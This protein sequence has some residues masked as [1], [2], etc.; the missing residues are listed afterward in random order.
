MRKSILIVGLIMAVGL[1]G[2][3]RSRQTPDLPRQSRDV[4]APAPTRRKSALPKKSKADSRALLA[5]KGKALLPIVVSKDASKR[6][7]LAARELAGFLKRISGAEFEVVQGDGQRGIVVGTL[8][9]FPQP[10]A[11]GIAKALEIRNGFDGKEAYVIRSK[12]ERVLLL[13]ATELG[14]SHAVYRLLERLGC[15]WFFPAKEW[16]V[17]PSAPTLRISLKVNDRPAVLARRIWYQW[18][19]FDR[20]RGKCAADYQ[21]WARRNRMASSIKVHCGHAWDSIIRSNKKVFTEHPEYLALHI[22]RDKKTGK[23]VKQKRGGNKFCIANPGLVELCKERALNYFAKQPGA[24]MLSMDPSDGGGHCQCAACGKMGKVSNRVFY[25]ANEVAKAVAAKYPGKMIGLY[26][27]NLHSE[28]PD[29]ELNPNVYIQLTAGFIR[30]K[31]THGELLELWPKKCRNMGYYEYFS[32]YQW[33]W[34]MLPGSTGANVPYLRQRIPMYV[35]RGATS[36]DAESGN[37]WGLHGR[38]YIV[39]N[40]LMWNPKTNVDALLKDF[41]LKA[42][43][44]AARVMK[45]YYERLDP[46]NGPLISEHLLGLAYRDLGKA[47]R[48]AANRPDVLARLDHLKIYLRYFHLRWQLN[49]TKVKDEKKRLTLAILT[50]VYRSRYSYMN[51]WEAMRQFW[52]P[53]AAKTFGEPSW[54]FRYKPK[55]RDEVDRTLGIAD[56]NPWRVDK[57]YS[58][59]EI[60]RFFKE[61]LEFFQPQNVQE[62]KFSSDLVPVQFRPAKAGRPSQDSGMWQGGR[63]FAL[64]SVAGEPLVVTV[65]TGMIAWYRDRADAR[66]TVV[67]AKDKV[68]AKGRFP[69]DGKKHKITARVRA[70]GLYFLNFNDSSAGWNIEAEANVP[71]TLVLPRNRR[72]LHH[73]HSRLGYFYVPKGTRQI[74]YFWNGP[75]HY[76]YDPTGKRV[77]HVT[78]SG[79]FIIIPVP[80]G[81]DGKLWK[82][83]HLTTGHLWLFNVPSYLAWTPNALLVPREVAKKDDLELR[84]SR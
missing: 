73:G 60:D 8:R 68:I 36:I 54:S 30:G 14:A 22:T 62:L 48:L 31:Y 40:R 38:G 67:D 23:I 7:E 15:R 64:Y 46:G 63:S 11:P 25:L 76:V 43:G 32:V 13:G 81:M 52:T 9:Q 70:K 51:H 61:G 58:R 66:Y 59:Q 6:I 53:R 28:P 16:E 57:A 65:K 41:Y 3:V 29:F 35:K 2:C 55:P 20:A 78:A 79:K 27:Y 17:I 18:G 21:N 19:F 75:Y 80:E 4:P 39:A 72:F 12:A 10:D 24:D 45:R 1:A 5:D 37:N 71:L 26:A 34:D 82:F 69:L 77:K 83:S 49:R 33:N 47:A 42:F 44:P 56:T 50:H 74:E 84:V